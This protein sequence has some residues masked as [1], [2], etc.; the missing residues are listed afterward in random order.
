MH[1]T[2]QRILAPCAVALGLLAT[3]GPAAADPAPYEINAVLPLT[4]SAAFL[5][6]SLQ[7]ALQLVEKRTNATGGIHGRPMKLVIYDDASNPQTDVQLTS[8]LIAKKVPVIFDGGPVAMCRAV[9]PLVTNGP[10]LYCLS[11]ALYPPTGSY[12]FSTS[13]SSEDETRAL[14]NYMRSRN[15]KRIGVLQPTDATGQEFDRVIHQLLALP[16]NRGME[17]VAYERFAP[18]DLTITAQAERVKSAHPD[19]V[20]AWGTGA[21]TATEYRALQDVGLDVPVV[22]ANGNQNY[23]SMAQ[24]ASILP[25]DYYQYAMKWPLYEKLRPGPIKTA[26]AE[27]Y[28]AYAV[29]GAKPDI[30]ASGGWDPLAIVVSLLRTLPEDVTATQLRDAL[31][32]LHGYAGVNGF[33]DFRLGNQRGLNL[34][35][36]IVVRWDTGTR[37]F[38]PVSG[39]GG[40]PL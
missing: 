1:A 17:L 30:G 11:P 21:A 9:V 5:G 22:G 35:D 28:H 19:V 10:V 23:A 33:Y 27:M 40:G 32:N 12:A 14:V 7:Q 24:W 31:L 18:T 15:W 37:T 36:C 2:L 39:S 13:G 4:G 34:K 6:A 8:P 25:R 38:V 20:M 3:G 29:V 16:E 26:M